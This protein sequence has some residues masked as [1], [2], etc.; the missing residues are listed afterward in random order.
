MRRGTNLLHEPRREDGERGWRLDAER[1][2]D[3][4]DDDDDVCATIVRTGTPATQRAHAEGVEAGGDAFD[5]EGV[6]EVPARTC[7]NSLNEPTSEVE[8]RS[9]GPRMRSVSP[10]HKP[11][12]AARPPLDG[13]E[14][15]QMAKKRD[16]SEEGQEGAGHATGDTPG[17]VGSVGRGRVRCVRRVGVPTKRR[18]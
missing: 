16:G 1:H 5:D 17:L 9:R 12:S 18:R 13:R 6:P 10:S 14:E 2:G 3:D 4:D 11:R 15:G 7:T 8:M